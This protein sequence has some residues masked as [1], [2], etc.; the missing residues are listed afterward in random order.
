[1]LPP[2]P[3]APRPVQTLAWLWRPWP[4][5]AGAR[6]RYGDAFTIRI[7]AEPPWVVLS[8]PAAVREVFTGDPTLFHAGEGNRI[9]LPLLGPNSVLL[10]D[11]DAHL[12]QRKLLLP[13]F[14]G[15][16]LKGWTATMTEIAEREIG[17]WERGATIAVRDRMQDVTLDIVVRVIFGVRDGEGAGE[18]HDALKRMLER[19]TGPRT[20]ALLA[21]L[22]PERVE[23]S[24]LL[25]R[26]L[27][28]VDALLYAAIG[29]RRAA[30][31]LDG[32]DDVLSLLL[33]ARHDDGSP[34]S[35]RELRDELLTLL[36]AGHE[37]TASALGWAA[38]RLARHPHAWD[39]LAEEAYADAV[40]KET[41]R[42]RP[43]LPVVVRRLTRDAEVAGLPLRAGTVVAPC[44]QLVHRRE[45]VY[46]EPLAF[47]PERFLDAR[48]GTYT[49]FPFGG[50][51]RRCIGAAFAELEMRVVLQAMGRRVRLQPAD[52]RPEP[53][54][55]RAI[56]LVPGRG[57]R[58]VVT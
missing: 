3:R 53:P 7:G 5:L 15:D 12:R 37:T 17:S 28:P 27:E 44:I 40:V 18:L 42:L 41:L 19:T 36:V 58:V 45:D 1:M 25:R 43:V 55:R 51:I 46:P 32:R 26:D 11:E 22:G 14:H 50:G 57:G 47:R 20:M 13:P 35:D 39:R 29:R 48:P 31:D 38:E 30:A 34:M 52:P 9:L 10:L 4:F 24:R 8:D 21:M 2:G 6:R 33:Q 23:G 16:R 49:W 56:T 54:H